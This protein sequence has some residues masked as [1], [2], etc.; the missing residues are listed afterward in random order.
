MP[1]MLLYRPFLLIAVSMLVTFGLSA[2]LPPYST[3][4]QERLI[5]PP[6]AL[7]PLSIIVGHHVDHHHVDQSLA[8]RI[9]HDQAAVTID[10]QLENPVGIYFA[11]ILETGQC[12]GG[13]LCKIML[14]L[15]GLDNS[16]RELRAVYRITQAG[17]QTDFIPVPPSA[18]PLVLDTTEEQAHFFARSLIASFEPINIYGC[19]LDEGIIA[20]ALL[21]DIKLLVDC[22]YTED[23]HCYR[24][25]VVAT[26]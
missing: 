22:H 21:E 9:R 14:T 25:Q 10:R 5:S 12:G 11:A 8:A 7:A 18:Y 15:T 13:L 26:C 6:R 20:A 19:L 4:S 16:V 17:G 23:R 2:Y 1:L 3:L 24:S